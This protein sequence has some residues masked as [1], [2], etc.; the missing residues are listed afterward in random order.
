DGIGE[1]AQPRGGAG[2]GRAGGEPDP[3]DVAHGG[4]I[5]LA[6]AA[7]HLRDRQVLVELDGTRSL[8]S[9]PWSKRG[10]WTKSS[11]RPVAFSTMITKHTRSG[12]QLG[13][14]AAVYLWEIG[15]M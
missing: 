15:S 11:V 8:R 9:S 1:C 7:L 3:Q 14:G 10:L 12:P 5:T 4:G 13:N 6:H 2:K